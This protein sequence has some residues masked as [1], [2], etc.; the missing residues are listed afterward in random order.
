[1]LEINKGKLISKDL[2]WKSQIYSTSGM[3]LVSALYGLLCRSMVTINSCQCYRAIFNKVLPKSYKLYTLYIYHVTRP[4]VCPSFYWNK[5]FL[6]LLL[7]TLQKYFK[8]EYKI[9]VCHGEKMKFIQ[10]KHSSEKQNV[11][12][13]VMISQAISLA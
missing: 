12:R 9:A 13:N 4:Q 11:V 3:F 7:H 2:N 10:S 6:F 8:Q 1:M 5:S